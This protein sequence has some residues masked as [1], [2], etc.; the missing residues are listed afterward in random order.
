LILAALQATVD[1][2]LSDQLS[3]IPIHQMMRADTQ[4]LRRRAEQILAQLGELPVQAEIGAALAQVGGGSLPRTTINSV[5][6][7]L[8]PRDPSTSVQRLAELLRLGEEPVVGYIEQGRVR[9]DLRTIFPRQDEALV[10]AIRAA[11]VGFA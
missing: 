11:A 1:P 9:L 7:D 5:T 10:K 3:H 2:L 4:D 6:I 8:Q